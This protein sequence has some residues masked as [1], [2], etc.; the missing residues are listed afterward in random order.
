M[1]GYSLIL[2]LSPTINHYYKRNS[3][4]GVRISDAG[5]AFRKE[6]WVAVKQ[7]KMPKLK[8]RVCLVV[9]VFPRNR[10][11]QDISNRVKALEDALQAAGAFLN[12]E[13]I[14][15]LQVTRGAVV[16]GGRLEVMLGEIE[17]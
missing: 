7:S 11:M 10:R 12:D 3:N 6:V 17:E 8:G 1:I 13:Q 2:P 16:P 15:D 4:G 5:L 14:D 9:R